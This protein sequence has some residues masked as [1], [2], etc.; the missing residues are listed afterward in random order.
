MGIGNIITLEEI[1]L[2]SEFKIYNSLT[3]I[4]NTSLP[5]LVIGC[6]FCKSLYGVNLDFNT[7]NVKDNIYWTFTKKELRKN[8][9]NDLEKF[10]QLSFEESVKKIKY[11]YLD[12][13]ISNYRTNK[14]IIKKL[15]SLD[16]PISYLKGDMIYIYSNNII[17]GVD[18]NL[19]DMVEY[20]RNKIIKKIKDKSLVFLEGSEIL[21]EYGEYMERLK[22]NYKFIP[23]IYSFVNKS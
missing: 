8:Y 23:Y 5:T 18:L 1:N 7:C 11:V 6:E 17:F 3:N 15:I 13:I 21:L 4:E 9:F 10:I 22:N 14:K 20:N 12:L 2:G 19:V 16:K